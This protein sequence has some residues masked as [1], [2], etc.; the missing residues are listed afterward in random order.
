M[1][2]TG[3]GG[4][5]VELFFVLSGY[6]ITGIL[7]DARAQAEA[8]GVSKSSIIKSFYARRFLRIFPL[9]YLVIFITY[10]LGAVNIQQYIGWH[11]SYLTNFNIFFQ[12]K[13]IGEASHLWSLAVEEQ[14]YLLWPFVILFTPKRFLFATVVGFILLAP[15]FKL[16]YLFLDLEGSRLGVLPISSFHYLGAGALLALIERSRKF[17]Q[18]EYWRTK[19]PLSIKWIGIVGLTV[20]A[21]LQLFP[22]LLG[23]APILVLFREF[24]LISIFISITM[25]AAQGFNGMAGNLLAARPMVYIG[26]ISYGLYLFHNFIPYFTQKLLRSYDIA[27]VNPQWLLLLNLSMLLTLSTVSWH[28]FESQLNK[29]KKN[30]PY[31]RTASKEKP[32]LSSKAV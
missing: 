5:G 32:I 17:R 28:L 21:F 14:F 10:L 27:H 7:L 31:L 20:F 18:D 25:G 16:L 29:Y 3:L 24:A 26:Q 13:W 19:M 12:D 1:R 2:Q 6:L 4:L 9:Y 30:F 23:K 22:E 15:T 11:L 8:M